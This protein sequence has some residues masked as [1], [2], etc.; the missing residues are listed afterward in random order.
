MTEEKL[1]KF[2]IRNKPRYNDLDGLNVDL[3]ELA[4]RVMVLPGNAKGETIKSNL[5]GIKE[6]KGDS[7]LSSVEEK[8]AELGYPVY[9]NTIK[10]DKYYPE[11]LNLLINIVYKSI[12]NAGDKDIFLLGRGSAKISFFAKLMMRHFVSLEMLKKNAPRYWKMN[13]DFGE[14]Q[15]TSIDEKNKELLVRVTNYNKSSVSC[16]FQGGYFYETLRLVVGESLFI[17]EVKCVHAGDSCHEYKAM[18]E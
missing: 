11:S 3:K 15:I 12:F 8:M 10:V 18:W 1:E 7:G 6:M 9:L 17:E 14:L 4:D 2:F 16:V 13:L 5:L